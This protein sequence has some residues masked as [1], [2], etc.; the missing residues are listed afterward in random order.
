MK[1]KACS[2]QG[3]SRGRWKGEYCY[4]H[5]R[6][7]TSTEKGAT[8]NRKV[9]SSRR[10]VATFKKRKPL[11]KVADKRRRELAI[12]SAN[13]KAYLEANPFCA[14]FPWLPATD[15]HHR[16]GRENERL[17]DM[18]FWIAVSRPG[19]DKIHNNPEW[20][21]ENGYLLLKNSIQKN[22][23]LGREVFE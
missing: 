19:H 14:V 13:R 8:S 18:E 7:A 5:S 11:K 2:V 9:D 20:A 6:V 17:N 4:G 21:Y 15:I 3:C 1:P 22:E 10:K 12:Y 16:Y 23:E